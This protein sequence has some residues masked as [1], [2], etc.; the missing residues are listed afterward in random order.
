MTL[1]PTARSRARWLARQ[2]GVHLP[3]LDLLP[4]S[5]TVRYARSAIAMFVSVLSAVAGW[6]LVGS[7]SAAGT[8]LLP[9]TGLAV[10]AGLAAGIVVWSVDRELIS[11][12]GHLSIR[13]AIGTVN[14]L[15]VGEIVL[16]ALFAPF[17][18]DQIEDYRADT[19]ATA[20]AD[21][22]TTYDGAI[23]LIDDAQS[24][25]RPDEPAS[26]TQARDDRAAALTALAEAEDSLGFLNEL[27]TAEVTG[28]IVVGDD[29]E[30]LTSGRPGDQGVATDSLDREIAAAEQALARA[31]SELEQSEERLQEA[32]TAYSTEIAQSDSQAARFDSDRTIA[33][34]ERD[35]SLSAAEEARTAPVGL[36]RR[37]DLFHHAVWTDAVL[38]VAVLA[39]HVAVLAAELSVVL[40]AI[41]DRRRRTRLYPELVEHIDEKS[42][43]A[44]PQ[45]AQAIVDSSIAHATGIP[46]AILPAIDASVS[47]ATASGGGPT[48]FGPALPQAS[49]EPNTNNGP[50]PKSK[51]VHSPA[52]A[53]IN[54][55]NAPA[56]AAPSSQ[57]V[58]RHLDEILQPRP[59]EISL[60]RP[61]PEASGLGKTL[62]PKQLAVLAYLAVSRSART[63]DV[64]STF[65]PESRSHSAADNAISAIR[66]ALGDADDGRPRLGS[67]ER[68][69]L[70]L[71]DDVGSDWA[72]LIELVGAP[73]PNDEAVED[74][75]ATLAAALSLIEGRPCSAPAGADDNWSW[76]PRLLSSDGHLG[77][78][79]RLAADRLVPLAMKTD[80]PDLASWAAE[81]ARVVVPGYEPPPHLAENG[82]GA[83]D[84]LAIGT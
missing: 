24:A 5:E 21:A 71:S 9:R 50:S 62:R 38:A 81:Q 78:A 68:G 4:A 33:Q 43:N 30:Q 29:G 79:A 83:T 42:V 64:R 63:A 39:V 37:I 67:Q 14:A 72:R 51:P 34:Q 70:T 31:E 40:W 28:R 61:T 55:N 41:N 8:P 10:A 48:G 60:L 69:Q 58:A 74:Q 75:I 20:I 49:L 77:A 12:D 57:D 65:W 52:S 32:E 26:L 54:S 56:V 66:R 27:R 53:S 11:G 6:A 46:A 82:A 73:A 84:R 80:R 2:T 15:F 7:W 47:D 44:L 25:T 18:D 3:Y 59:I 1:S 16:L 13:A 45:L 36:L 22:Q 17:V 23:A 19:H 35:A 76:V